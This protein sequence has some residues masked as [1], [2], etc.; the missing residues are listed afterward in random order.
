[1]LKDSKITIF[2]G[3]GLL[4]SAISRVLEKRNYTNVKTPTNKEDYK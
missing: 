2:G 1:M 3:N 4:G